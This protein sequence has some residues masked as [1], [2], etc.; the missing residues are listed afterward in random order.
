MAL[1]DRRKCDVRGAVVDTEGT[2]ANSGDGIGGL[3][4]AIIERK[5]C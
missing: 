1:D 4:V 3:V 5:N 2:P